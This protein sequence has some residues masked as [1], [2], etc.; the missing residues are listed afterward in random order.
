MSNGLVVSI[1]NQT[2]SADSTL[3]RADTMVLCLVAWDIS[4]SEAVISSVRDVQ[5]RNRFRCGFKLAINDE[6]STNK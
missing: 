1:Y 4:N 2:S 5:V 6:W 3:T